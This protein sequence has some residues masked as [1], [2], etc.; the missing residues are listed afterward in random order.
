MRWAWMVGV[1]VWCGGAAAA[2]ADAG[3]VYLLRHGEKVDDSPGARLSEAGH[4][5]ARRWAA[6]LREVPVT[7]V[8]VSDVERTQQTAAPLVAD[9]A[10]PRTV[11]AAE[12]SVRELPRRMAQLKPTDVAVVFSHSNILPS[13]W[14]ALGCRTPIT[15]ADGDYD[16]VMLIIPRKGMEPSCQALRVD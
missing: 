12:A 1:A 8:F 9:R 11:V 16:R 2:R 7:Q 3:A 6:M 10:V 14:S 13:L 5:R 4:A 15:V